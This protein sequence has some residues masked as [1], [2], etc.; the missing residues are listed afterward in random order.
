MLLWLAIRKIKGQRPKWGLEGV[1]LGT[2]W[3]FLVAKTTGFDSVEMPGNA[4]SKS[5]IFNGTCIHVEGGF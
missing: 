5:C 4:V 3:L 2:F 1:F